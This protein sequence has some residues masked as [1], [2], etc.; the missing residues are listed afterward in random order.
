MSYTTLFM[1][2]T[3]FMMRDEIAASVSYGRR[4]QSAV[5]ASTES[6]ALIAHVYSYV[7]W[8]PM[9]PTDLTGRRTANACH[10]DLKLGSFLTSSLTRRSA[11]WRSR[12]FSAVTSPSILT[13]RP[14]PG[15]GWRSRNSASIPITRPTARTSSLK[16][17]RSGSTS[18]NL[19]SGGSPPTLWWLLIVCEGP[20]S[21]E[22]DSMTSG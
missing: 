18:S 10:I 1:P 7:L 8:S 17:S 12:T 5:I 21:A 11:S 2:R 20:F 9:T 19:R 15:N 13:P 4:V 6:T 3:S 14:G 22:D 16:R